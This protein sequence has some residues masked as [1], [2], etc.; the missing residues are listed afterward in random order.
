MPLSGRF[1]RAVETAA[2]PQRSAEPRSLAIEL[3]SCFTADK[4]R[5]KLLSL[6]WAE[7][8]EPIQIAVMRAL[9]EDADPSLGEKLLELWS[10][11]TP[12]ARRIALDT[13]LAREDRTKVWLRSA[14]GGAVSAAEVDS[15]R[16]DVLKNHANPEIKSLAEEAFRN[17]ASASRQAVI[18]EYQPVLSM[19]GR[20][21]EGA[22]VFE[23]TCSICHQVGGKGVNIGPNLA[24]NAAQ[25]ASTL[26][27]HILD[28]NQYV[29]P[30]YVMYLAVDTNGITHTGLLAAQTS[31]SITPK[32]PKGETVTLLK[33]AIEELTSSRKSL[34]PEGLEQAVP[35][36]AMADL[37][38]YLQEMTKKNAGDPNSERDRGTV[39]GTLIEE[40]AKSMITTR[41]R[42]LQSIAGI[43]DMGVVD[44][45]ETR[46]RS[47]PRLPNERQW[48]YLNFIK[49]Q[50]AQLRSGDKPPATRE[51]WESRRPD[52]RDW[53]PGG[54]R[55]ARSPKR[56]VRYSPKCW[57]SC[58]ATAIASRRSSFRRCRGCG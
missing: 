43:R 23:K 1:D 27:T 30:S 21:D 22:K 33:S 8:P 41:R 13:M 57:A 39:A 29:L 40:D 7:S 25:S 15:L 11:F 49:A 2:N 35:L 17:V 4:A 51:E 6:L 18:A 20:I 16:R 10:G 32:K 47:S 34:M 42:F 46:S 48:E 52:L 14:I 53:Q 9:G 12:E 26:L 37:I 19:Q 5:A 28:P 31:T 50:A 54:M 58:S 38:A 56:R 24:S 44:C 55:S 36:Q 45:R 3:A